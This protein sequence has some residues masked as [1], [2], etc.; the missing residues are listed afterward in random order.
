M[1]NVELQATGP[2]ATEF[3]ACHLQVRGLNRLSLGGGNVRMGV[4]WA[5]KRRGHGYC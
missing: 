3:M 4:R 2:E 1:S 5:G